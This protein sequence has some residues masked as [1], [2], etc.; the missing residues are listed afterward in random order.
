M[1]TVGVFTTIGGGGLILS[2][3]GY[4]LCRSAV[5]KK[6]DA[7]AENAVAAATEAALSGPEEL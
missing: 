3:S 6:L 4:S 7:P 1:T 5:K 2:A